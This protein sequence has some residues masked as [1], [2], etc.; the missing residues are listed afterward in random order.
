M[1][2]I[3]IS[4]DYDFA[5]QQNY[6]YNGN[7]FQIGTSAMQLVSPYAL[8]NPYFT[9]LETLLA[10]TLNSFSETSSL[11]SG[12]LVKY[13][14]NVNNQDMYFDGGSNW[15]KSNGNF[16]Q[17]NTAAQINT[18]APYFNAG[19]SRIKPKI[20]LSTAGTNT[21]MLQSVSIS[22]NFDGYC[23][24]DDIRSALVNVPIENVKDEQVYTYIELAGQEID[25][26]ISNQYQLPISDGSTLGILRSWSIQHA[27]YNIYSYFAVREGKSVSSFAETKYKELLEKL[28][29]VQQGT[30]KLLGQ[31]DLTQY[32][33]STIN[34]LPTFNMGSDAGW[35][36]DANLLNDIADGSYLG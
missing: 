9:P 31:T 21:P 27:A 1:P 19:R 24:P 18:G 28:K 23:I 26:H 16:S 2:Q 22:Y 12:T 14:L 20:F 34:Y 33:S 13:I 25:F 36:V 8:T 10:S 3:S 6:N 5:Y 29:G 11:G 17:S 4:K 32:D 15:I 30:L 35:H 7:V